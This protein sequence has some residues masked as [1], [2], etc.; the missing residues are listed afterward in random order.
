MDS[1]KNT[2]ETNLRHSLALSHIP[3]IGPKTYQQLISYFDS[4]EQ[5]FNATSQ[6]LQNIQ[7]TDQI[8]SQLNQP[9]W[10]RVD[11]DLR[12]L[13]LENNHI[14]L[15]AS[16]EYP[17]LLSQCPD[18]PPVLYVHG[19]LSCISHL[20]LAIV[21]S[22]TPSASGKENAYRFAYS[23]AEAGLTITSGMAHGI[24]TAAHQ[25]A[26][27]AKG[28]T[29]AVMGTALDRVYP[30]QNKA[31]AHQIAESGALLSE[32]AI[33]IGPKAKNF[34]RRNR[35][36]SALSLGCLIVEAALKSGSL[37]T[38][39]HANEQG[40]EVFAIPGSIHNPLARGCHKLIRDGAKLVETSADIIFEL[41]PLMGAQINLAEQRP[42]EPL[43][44]GF[45]DDSLMSSSP[46][47]VLEP[48]RH[49]GIVPKLEVNE[50]HAL[51]LKE[52]GYDL[53]T[54]D[55]LV[56]RTLMSVEEVSSIL[57]ILELQEQIKSNPGGYYIR[58]N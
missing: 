27:A 29:V 19:N 49:K 4:A 13:E 33:G 3:G 16:P 7:I 38:A 30:A 45:G 50:D 56:T 32:F 54:I 31:L 48:S 1:S 34:P 2:S 46:Q 18:P 47:P 10:K 51:V 40:R 23:L 42:V 11:K 37:I 6:Q 5:V 53:V 52:M 25:G 12:W 43:T 28:K 17:D 55:T 58:I 20:Q 26:I 36:I 57:L 8:R 35:I 21:G 24:D 15:L 44:S 9:D 41:G 39:R 14:I 22:R